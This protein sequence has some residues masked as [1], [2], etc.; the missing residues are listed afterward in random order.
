VNGYV[1]ALRLLKLAAD[2]LREAE[3]PL[4]WGKSDPDL[5]KRARSAYRQ[6]EEFLAKVEGKP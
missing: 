2:A 6:A 4:T 5:A 3:V 1:E